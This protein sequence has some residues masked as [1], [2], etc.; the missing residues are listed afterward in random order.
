MN[1]STAGRK[2]TLEPLSSRLGLWPVLG[3]PPGMAA[4]SISALGY[5]KGAKETLTGAPQQRG[6]QRL[7]NLQFSRLPRGLS[8]FTGLPTLMRA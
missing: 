4:A 6:T 8:E 7:C 5:L 2:N 1:K 3:R